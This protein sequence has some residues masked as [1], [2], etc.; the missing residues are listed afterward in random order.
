MCV[1]VYTQ[2]II[3]IYIYTYIHTHIHIYIYTHT[4]I[5]RYESS[6]CV[7]RPTLHHC[8]DRV[9]AAFPC[10]RFLQQDMCLVPIVRHNHLRVMLICGCFCAEVN[11]H[12]SHTNTCLG[13]TTCLTLLV[14]C[15]IV[16]LMR[17][18]SC[19]GAP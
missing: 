17:C 18:S 5:H 13:G 8:Q 6:A 1:C 14:Y 2:L 16:Y 9:F 4:Y 10:L 15:G 19:Q 12:N 3:Y 7:P 11:F